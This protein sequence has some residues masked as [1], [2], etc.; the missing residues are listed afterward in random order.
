MNNNILHNKNSAIFIA[1]VLVTGVFA[2]ISSSPLAVYGQQYEQ[3]SYYQFDPRMD[4]KSKSAK[5]FQKANCDNENINVNGIDQRQ[6]QSQLFENTLTDDANA[7]ITGQELTPEESLAAINGNGDPSLVNIDRNILNVCFNDNDN[8]LDGF[9]DARQ[10]QSGPVVVPPVDER[11]CDDCFAALDA[12]ALIAINAQLAQVGPLIIGGITIP[13]TVDT[14]AELCLFLNTTP[15]SLSGIQITAFI[16]FFTNLTGVG[17]A[18]ASL[19][20]ACLLE[21]GAFIAL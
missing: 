19:L 6:A 15:L 5:Q 1:A 14:T 10:D 17:A 13:A 12:T 9:F 2:T 21:V 16:T 20:V 3:D 18:Q 7:G 8:D 11:T 4:D